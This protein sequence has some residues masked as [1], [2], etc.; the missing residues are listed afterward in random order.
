MSESINV[1][2]THKLSD[3]VLHSFRAVSPSI[4]L[5]VHPAEK[6]KDIPHRVWAQADVVYT[7]WWLPPAT[8]ETPIK[9]IHSHFAGIDHLLEDPFIK[10]N[11]DIIITTSSGIHVS[12]IGEYVLGMILALGHRLPTML[13]HQARGEWSSERYRIFMPQELSK[14]T[15]GI[16]GYGRLGREISRLCKCFGATVLATK[17]N[18]MHPEDDDYTLP[19]TGDPDCEQVDRLYPPEATGFMLKECD[20]VIITLPLT[21]STRNFFGKDLIEAMKPS[22]YLINVGRGAIVDEVALL[23]ALQNE[24]IAGAAF[25]VFAEE[26]LPSDHPL[27]KAPNT[28]ISPHISGNMHD[29]REKAGVVFEENLRRYVEGQTLMNV[30]S[31]E[32]G[33]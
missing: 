8:L 18:V 16:M 26:P 13:E 11:P 2:I 29:Y 24:R 6:A 1:L 15:V 3:D 30:V 28:I 20:F 21:A 33:Y 17:R 31:R 19:G 23:E 32:Q 27:W 5:R 4:K 22:A 12:K 25:D 7:T 10:A 14:S 9:W